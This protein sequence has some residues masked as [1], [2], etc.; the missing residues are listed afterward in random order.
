MDY[1]T[2]DTFSISVPHGYQEIIV[3]ID[4]TERST[5]N[6]WM[7]LPALTIIKHRYTKPR[8]MG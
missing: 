1:T 5:R 6:K 4:A 7:S 3:T 8:M 2:L